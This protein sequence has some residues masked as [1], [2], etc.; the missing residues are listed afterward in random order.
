MLIAQITDLHMRRDETP[1]SGRVVT[2]PYTTAAVDAVNAWAPDAVLVTGDLTDLG[3]EVEYQL[4]RAEL[5]R[6]DAP[7]FVLP[8]NHDNRE[9][10]RAAFSDHAYL[11]RTGS[12]D[13]VIDDG[14]VRLIGLDTVVPR[15]G[16]GM[17][18]DETLVWLDGVLAGDTRPTIVALHHPPF[19]T[20]MPGMDRIMCL[21][22]ADLEPIL[23]RHPHVERLVAGHHHRPVQIVWGG[24]LCLIAPSVAHQVALDFAERPMAEWVLEPPAMMLHRWTAE[25]GVISHTAYIGDY[26]GPQPFGHDPDY[27]PRD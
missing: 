26:G 15:E 3:S 20:G 9:V 18:A 1:L 8:G 22:G 4:V 10:M 19:P 24:T 16:H 23:A 12:L 5:D 13:W 7:F 11:P 6:I 25:T 2:R 27:P 21:N 14:P 17:L